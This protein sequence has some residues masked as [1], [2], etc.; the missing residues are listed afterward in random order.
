M[1]LLDFFKNKNKLLQEMNDKHVE[2]NCDNCKYSKKKIAYC[3]DVL[4]C[5]KFKL[6]VDFDS[7]CKLHIFSNEAIKTFQKNMKLKIAEYEK[8][9][10]KKPKVFTK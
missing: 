3:F 7:K 9:K 6:E 2:K 4:Y 8:I 1:F 10:K 5:K